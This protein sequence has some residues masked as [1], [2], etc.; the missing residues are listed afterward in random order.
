MYVNPNLPSVAGDPRWLVWSASRECP[1]LDR[2]KVLGCNTPSTAT[3]GSCRRF[4]GGRTAGDAPAVRC[5]KHEEVERHKRETERC[6]QLRE[7]MQWCQE[8]N[9]KGCAGSHRLDVILAAGDREGAI[10]RRTRVNVCAC[11]G[12][13][14]VCRQL[15]QRASNKVF[16]CLRRKPPAPPA[17]ELES[18]RA[19]GER[20]AHRQPSVSHS[21]VVS[22]ES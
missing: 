14:R 19:L 15:A 1:E 17:V 6:Q 9:L 4:R 10:N 7:A 22:C 8:N 3:V 11:V 20:Q 16:F 18:R 2:P 5:G 13:C 21:C 12:S